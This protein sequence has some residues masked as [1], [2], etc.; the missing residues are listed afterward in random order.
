MQ[1]SL[2]R[3]DYHEYF[4]DKREWIL[5]LLK[6]CGVSIG[7]AYFFYKSFWGLP[8]MIIVGAFYVKTHQQKTIKKSR[9]EL[10]IQFKECIL[11]VSSSLQAGYA[12]ENAFMESREAIQLLFGQESM[13]YR[14]LEWIRRGFMIN[15]SLEEL[16]MD[17]AKRSNCEEIE[18]FSKI[19]SIAKK[20]GGNI[21]EII[22]FSADLICHKVDTKQE[23]QTLL[24]GRFME[25]TIMR[26]MPFGILLYISF[27]NPG[28]F[29]S[30]Y[31]NL[32]GICIMSVCLLIYLLAYFLGDK[33]LE[34]I[35]RKVL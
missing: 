20:S 22:N 25:Q 26:I 34:Q 1:I 6:G 28:Y 10:L 9:E 14:E 7:L 12:L 13:M 35:M 15:I 30:L 21:T 4:F 23:I 17:F 5:M 11:S 31:H 33:I 16:L 3:R 2:R 27:S 29:D 32:Q 24:S 18:Q 8:F 19:L